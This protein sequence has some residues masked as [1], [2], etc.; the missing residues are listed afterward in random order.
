VLRYANVYG[1]RQDPL[2]EAG[3]VAIFTNKMLGNETPVINGDGRQTRDY[4]YVDD[5]VG[6]NLLSLTKGSGQ[7]YNIGTANETDVN[8]L[9][10]LLKG[11]TGYSGEARYGEAKIGEQR[12]SVIDPAKAK[13]ELGWRLYF[14][15][16]EGL[17]RTVEWF[18]IKKQKSRKM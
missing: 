3:V 11:I 17:Q 12:R 1:P 5:V 18:R 2:G 16:R 8:E 7:V 4:V 15:L 14:N 13:Q 10:G 9:F 6:A